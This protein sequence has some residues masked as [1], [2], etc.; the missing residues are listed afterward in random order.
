M[1]VMCT[2]Y[3]HQDT[4]VNMARSILDKDKIGAAALALADEAGIGAVTARNL[5]ERLDV[6]PMALY[7]HVPNLG[8]VVDGLLERVLVDARILDHASPSLETFLLETFCRI[9]A[10]LVAHPAVLPL[11][12]TPAGYGPAALAV[13]DASL[14]RFAAAGHSA[15]AGVRIFHLLLSYTIGAASVRAAMGARTEAPSREAFE[16]LPYVRAAIEPLGRFGS[17]RSFRNGLAV[18]LEATL[19]TKDEATTRGRASK[20]TRARRGT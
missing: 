18:L 10:C 6:T 7:R 19:E 20:R 11:L 16:R 5:A 4:I 2:L 15:A 3:T 1:A 14:A 9:H 17:E 12:G 8:S 13:V